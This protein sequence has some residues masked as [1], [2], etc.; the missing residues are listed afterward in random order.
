MTKLKSMTKQHGPCG[1]IRH[2][3]WCTLADSLIRLHHSLVMNEIIVILF[4]IKKDKAVQSCTNL[5]RS[6]VMFVPQLSKASKK[7][8]I[9]AV[10][11][12]ELPH[13]LVMHHVVANISQI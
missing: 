8:C 12:E 2:Q 6:Y 1:F 5:S 11:L 3:K 7:G 9:Y 4:E 10:P 13:R